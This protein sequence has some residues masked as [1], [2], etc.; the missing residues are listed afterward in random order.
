MARRLKPDEKARDA[1]R[2]IVSREAERA[3]KDLETA[4]N[5]PHAAR[6]RIKKIRAALR[7][8]R[9][10]MRREDFAQENAAWREAAWL[11]APLRD[12]G[13]RLET[14]ARLSEQVDEPRAL[15]ALSILRGNLEARAPLD[16]QSIRIRAARAI[17]R[18]AERAP[19]LRA[20][21]KARAVFTKGIQRA[22]R[23][24][25][26]YGAAAYESGDT[27]DFHEWRQSVKTL[28][29]QLQ[30]L[31][32]EAEG[33]L[34]AWR[35]RC[36]ELGEVLGEDHDLAQLT[37]TLS[38]HPE[39][40]DSD[41]QRAALADAMTERSLML[42]ARARPVFEALYAEKPRAFARRAESWLETGKQPEKAAPEKAARAKTAGAAE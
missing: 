21:G 5:P 36:A 1:L 3:L 26:E 30:I 2:R 34:G 19:R 11:L 20:K 9:G 39:L 40:L 25:G 32:P 28:A 23:R 16:E 37:V 33:E 17:A 27:A 8:A 14:L 6:R 12:H 10:G 4:A 38:L 35:I 18:G 29:L 24:G 22:Y 15:A 7:L 13:A 41:E 31:D 42:R